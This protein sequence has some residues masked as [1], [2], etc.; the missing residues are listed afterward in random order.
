MGLLFFSFVVVLWTDIRF[1]SSCFLLSFFCIEQMCVCACTRVCVFVCVCTVAGGGYEWATAAWS[2]GQ[3]GQLTNEVKIIKMNCWVMEPPSC[4]WPPCLPS[5]ILAHLVSQRCTPCWCNRHK[6][7][8]HQ[9]V[10]KFVRT[11]NSHEILNWDFS[12]I[13][14]FFF[15]FLCK[16][17]LGLIVV[18]Y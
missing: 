9:E 14:L 11:G 5:M 1:L 4:A 13:S 8:K 10:V 16:V 18:Y 6:Y 15:N 7:L 12:A 3:Y 2:T 17:S